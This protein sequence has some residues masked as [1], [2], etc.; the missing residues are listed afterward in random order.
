MICDFK[1][2][3]ALSQIRKLSPEQ[4]VTQINEL[5]EKNKLI[6]RWIKTGHWHTKQSTK[7]KSKLYTYSNCKLKKNYG[8]IT[9]WRNWTTHTFLYFS[10]WMSNHDVFVLSLTFLEYQKLNVSL[11]TFLLSP[12]HNVLL[13]LKFKLFSFLQYIWFNS[14]KTNF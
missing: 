10:C 1:M 3:A 5:L 14:L 9:F 8:K 4:T 13:H 12:N 11:L 7:L 6:K 2:Q